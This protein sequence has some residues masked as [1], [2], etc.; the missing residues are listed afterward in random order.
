VPSAKLDW[1]AAGVAQ[2][3]NAAASGQQRLIDCVAAMPDPS[4]EGRSGVGLIFG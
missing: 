4:G 1:A 2:T 3:S